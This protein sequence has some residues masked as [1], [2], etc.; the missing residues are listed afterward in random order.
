MGSPLLNNIIWASIS[1]FIK[2][3]EK[4]GEDPSSEAVLKY[5]CMYVSPPRRNEIAVQFQRG[6]FIGLTFFK[7]NNIFYF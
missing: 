4:N 6:T 2:K 3:E 7:K 5:I 1:P